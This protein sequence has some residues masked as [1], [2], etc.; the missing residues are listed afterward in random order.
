MWLAAKSNAAR[1]FRAVRLFYTQVT[2]ESAYVVYNSGPVAKK[3]TAGECTPMLP[4]A[5]FVSLQS[6]C[7]YGAGGHRSDGCNG[8]SQN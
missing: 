5:T 3:L 6:T 8:I 1:H 2:L 4:L 7:L